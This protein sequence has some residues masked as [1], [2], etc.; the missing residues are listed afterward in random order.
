MSLGVLDA[1]QDLER[2]PRVPDCVSYCRLGQWAKDSAGQRD[3][4]AGPNIGN[5]SRP[6][7]FSEA[8]GLFVR[9]SPAGQQY[10]ARLEKTHGTGKALTVLAYTF[11]RAVSDMLQRQTAC[12]LPLVPRR[13]WREAG[14][15]G[16]A[17]ATSG[18]SRRSRSGRVPT[19][20]LR[21]Q[22]RLEAFVPEP[23]A[24]IGRPLL[25]QHIWRWSTRLRCAAPLSS[26]VP[27]WRTCP[28]QPPL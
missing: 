5:A 26:L 2:F 1:I 7:A 6:G 10:L 20:R 23:G 11:A 18:S 3:G 25:L 4:T 24:L 27:T 15:P 9:A 12:D 22:R 17:L 28:V 8:A 13:S 14:E 16:A 19:W 21:P